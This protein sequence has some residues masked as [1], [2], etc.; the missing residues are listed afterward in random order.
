MADVRR[1]RHL[2]QAYEEPEPLAY[3]A[4]QRGESSQMRTEPM[5]QT[6]WE[7]GT[8]HSLEC[9]VYKDPSQHTDDSWQT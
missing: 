3:S 7:K 6:R 1:Q 5:M 2:N 4:Y 8:K 9:H